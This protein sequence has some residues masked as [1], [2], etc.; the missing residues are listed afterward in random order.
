MDRAS[1]PRRI[2]K[3]VKNSAMCLHDDLCDTAAERTRMKLE[4]DRGEGEVLRK[5]G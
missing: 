5:E 2:D 3:K 4:I 1:A